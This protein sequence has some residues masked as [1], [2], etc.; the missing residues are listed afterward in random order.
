MARALGVL[1][2]LLSVLARGQSFDLYGV[3]PRSIGMGGTQGASEGDY[4]ATFYNPAMLRKGGI[5]AAYLWSKPFLSITET[6]KTS[7]SQV[8]SA[9]TPVDYSGVAV[10]FAVPLT[11]LLKD[12]VTLGVGIFVPQRHVFRSHMIDER[13]AYFFRYDNAPERIQ[14]VLGASVRPFKWLSLGV[15]TQLMSDYGGEARFAAVLGTVQNGWVTQRTLSNEVTGVAAPLVGLDLGPFKGVKLFAAWRG[16]VKAVYTLPILVDL[17][18]FGGMDINVNG[19]SHFAPHTVSVGASWRLLDDRLFLTA[20]VSW[21]HWAAVPPLIADIRIT[22]DGTLLDLGFHKDVISREIVMGFSDVVVPKV[23]IEFG[24]TP[25]LKLRAGYGLRPTPA[26]VQTGRTNF[27]DSTAHLLSAGGGYTL[28]DP[29]QM[30]S[31]L[32]LEGAVQLAVTS[33]GHV[34]K[35]GPNLNPNYQFGG[36]VLT[37][38]AGARYE[39]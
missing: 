31:G 39:F 1:I 5:G 29:L 18:V 21:E 23:G 28:D 38:S 15:G 4:A 24:V 37:L 3:G 32:T 19:V 26:P 13:T 11:G 17:G 35:A 9:Q 10:G 36:S 8:L 22:L 34:E 12:R 25:R 27:V 20:D 30:A 33:G 7:P 2:V 6:E 14:I 16:E